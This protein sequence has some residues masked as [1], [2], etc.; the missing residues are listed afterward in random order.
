MMAQVRVDELPDV[1]TAKQVARVLQCT[2]RHVYTLCREGRMPCRK[3]GRLVRIPKVQFVA[4][5]EGR[6]PHEAAS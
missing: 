1:L 5:L 6:W 4:W 3:V 2:V